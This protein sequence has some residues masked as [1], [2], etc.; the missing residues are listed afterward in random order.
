MTL[1]K[2][3][4]HLYLMWIMQL[5]L[6]LQKPDLW[7]KLS[8]C[9]PWNFECYIFFLGEEEWRFSFPLLQSVYWHQNVPFVYS[10]PSL[11][12]SFLNTKSAGIFLGEKCQVLNWTW[13]WLSLLLHVTKFVRWC[14]KILASIVRSERPSLH[15]AKHFSSRK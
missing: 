12:R 7:Q 2:R 3:Y 10:F 11:F 9:H 5:C 13:T 6:P 4:T 15:I 8:K 1:M 14:L